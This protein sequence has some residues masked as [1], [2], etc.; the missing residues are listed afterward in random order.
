MGSGMIGNV[1]RVLII[2]QKQKQQDTQTN[3]KLAPVQRKSPSRCLVEIT[4]DLES[5]EMKAD[6]RCYHQDEIRFF[7]GALDL[8]ELFGE[9]S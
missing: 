5:Y 4:I 6:V 3:L 9:L 2:G 1:S 8:K 7:L